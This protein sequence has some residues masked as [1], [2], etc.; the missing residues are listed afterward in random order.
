MSSRSATAPPSPALVVGG[1]GMLSG[2]VQA[3][4]DQG[5]TTAVL[6]RRPGPP[7]RTGPVVAVPV[8]Y[9][10]PAALKDALF[11]AVRDTGRFR[12]AVLWVHTP[13]Q[14]SAYGVI[15][16]ALTDDAL[17]VEVLGSAAAAPSAPP[18]TAPAP[19]HGHRYRRVVL[20]FADGDDG[21]TRWLSHREI[22]E[23][24][25]AALRTPEDLR[26]IGRVRPWTDRPRT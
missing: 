6:A 2:T 7:A 16:Q 9:T 13:A 4:A 26:I 5:C 15:A 12:L 11:K 25:T 21:T 20:G 22:S 10:D 14:A 17:V 18:A 3:L 1:T 23:G 19:F 8:D 24:V